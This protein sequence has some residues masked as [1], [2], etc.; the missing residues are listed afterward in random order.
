MAAG[1]EPW[2]IN[3]K[4]NG[5]QVLLD[6]GVAIMVVSEDVFSKEAKNG[7]TVPLRDSDQASPCLN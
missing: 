6:T 3:G 4:V 7:N 5:K 1:R 2:S